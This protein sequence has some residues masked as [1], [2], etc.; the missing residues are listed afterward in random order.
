VTRFVVS[1]ATCIALLFAGG[2]KAMAL[3][4]GTKVQ[5]YKS[6]LAFPVDMAWV[7]GTKRIFF[8][9]KNTGKVR[10]MVGRRLLTRACVNLDVSSTGE[11]GALGIALHPHFNRN[12]KLYV[13]YT[14]ASPDDNRVT[15]FVVRNNRCRNPRHITK[16]IPASTGYHNGGQ[17]EFMNGKLFV[18]VGENHNAGQ[19]QRKDTRLGKI[20]RYNPDG[21][22]PRTNPFSRPGD[23][24]PV[25]SFGHRNPFG[26]THEPGTPRLY[27]SNNGPNCDD[28][29]NLIRKGRNYGW[30]PGYTCGTAGVGP[31]PK[32]PL[33]RWTPPIVPTDPWFYEGRMGRL[34]GDLYMGDFKDGRLRRFHFNRDGT[35]VK[36]GTTIFN[37]QQGI[38]DVA[39]G[40][41][42]W[43]Y[44]MTAPNGNIKRI[45]PE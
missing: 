41:G 44:F 27:E 22:I 24:N 43:L 20:L 6:N 18:S 32:P 4:D 1:I 10:V 5:T 36:R 29:L 39:K 31:N 7:E 42:G 25:W 19:A 14:H 3:P 16:G 13:Y 26:L 38:V 30:G 11:Q 28:E 40:P 37:A 21:T 35:R 45:V 8:T 9:E 12:H 15:R 17:L 33:K 23:R 34:S 2:G